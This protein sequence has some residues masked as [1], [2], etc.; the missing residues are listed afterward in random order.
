MTR[1]QIA[2]NIVLSLICLTAK[3]NNVI[4]QIGTPDGSAAEFALAPDCYEDYVKSDFG[5][6][7]R[8]FVVGHSTPAQD[9]C[10]V[11][12][13]PKDRW[14]GTSPTAGERVHSA[15]VLFCL[16]HVSKK[17][18]A[19]LRIR[20]VDAHPAGS[21]LK[22][23]VGELSRTF[24]LQGTSGDDAVMGRYDCTPGM[25]LEVPLVASDLRCGDN[26]ITFTILEGSWV[27]FDAV[28]LEGTALRLAD[29]TASKHLLK[30]K[31]ARYD[32]ADHKP[33]K[34]AT[35]ADYVDTSIGTGHS[36]WMIAP[37]PWM[38]FSM[39]KLS[40]DNQNSG[41]QAG[42]QPSIESLGCMSHIHEWTMTGLGMMPTNGSLQTEVGDEKDPDS[43]YRSR[44]DKNSE[45][46][47]L[48]YYS[49]RLTD[50]D[51]QLE[52][53]ATTRCA[54]QRYTFPKD[55]DG[56]VMV[57]LSIPAEYSYRIEDAEIRQVDEYR[58][59]GYSHQL[60][61]NVWSK[62]ANQEYTIHFVIEFNAPILRSGYWKNDER[63][64]G[65]HLKGEHLSKAGF[66]VEFDTKRQHRI[67]ARS[68]ISYVSIENAA[69]NLTEELTVPFGWNFDKVVRHQRQTWNELLGRIEIETDDVKEK[70]RFYTNLYRT[71]CRN[72]YSDV[73]GDWVGPDE[74]VRRLPDPEHDMALGCD[75]FWNTFWNLN[76]VW[77]L[78]YPEW[79]SR[80]VRSQLAMYDACGWL[81]KGPAGMEYV[82]VMVAEHEIP[83][84]VSAWQMGIRDF[85]GHHAL[86][87][88]VH[89]QTHAVRHVDGG[90]A[91][92]RDLE[93]YLKYHY[94]PCDKG[95]FSNT[96]EY[97]YDDWTVSQMAASLGDTA[98]ERIFAERAS[99]WRNAINP[100]NGYAH[101]RDSLGRFT[102]D[103]DPFKSGAN[104]QYVEGNAWQLSYFVPQDVGGLI[105]LMGRWAF[106]DRLEWGFVNSEPVRYNAPGDA[107]WDYPVVQG[108]QQSMHF[109][110][111]FNW[112]GRPD[113]TQRWTRSVLERYYGYGI[114]N[115]Y[116]GDEDQG[117]M[118]AWFVMAA[119]GLFQIDGGCRN[120]PIYELASPLYPKTTIH[121]GERYGR[122]KDFIIEARNTSEE[123]LYVNKATLNGKPLTTFFFPASEL[124]KGGR[125]V[126]E[127]A[128]EHKQT[129]DKE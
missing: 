23:Q 51:I 93:S 48:G 73:N 120:E 25:T 22:V 35:P 110:F 26:L 54:M 12:P 41:W 1:K 74:K 67:L 13:G 3:A 69:L 10:Y 70:V 92:N 90:F 81:A 47:P 76:Q 128:S 116:L 79:S 83:L 86:E 5:Y 65:Q 82:P 42:Y 29:S 7:D 61:P 39:V 97:A 57:D 32:L 105:D 112:A 40:P 117:Q 46:T 78:V 85:D 121:L 38:P 118:S 114:W 14:A 20:L 95:R 126:L 59:E 98:T 19:V 122:G 103:F 91:G 89:Q 68:A 75:A 49:V 53:T 2:T 64:T 17:A 113:L 77:N 37:G 87:A 99:W 16:S 104:A 106:V 28:T 8:F 31:S 80:W 102:A 34:D 18:R 84:M 44:I 125:L 66:Y 4:W 21:L 24:Q 52:A 55:R 56:R 111:L 127:M 108:N 43:G 62:D 63:F 33:K 88:M 15:N 72:C 36:R 101:L 107:Y 115:A 30:V 100:V 45:Q 9:F 96:L 27:V 109:A 60:T 119:L 124:L 50:T 129:N 6:E 58:L 94:V 11:L 123:N 71:L